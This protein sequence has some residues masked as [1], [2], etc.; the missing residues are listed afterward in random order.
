MRYRYY[1]TIIVFNFTIIASDKIRPHKCGNCKITL[2]TLPIC[3][4][5]HLPIGQYK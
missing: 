4:I 2:L 1:A 5:N 3:K